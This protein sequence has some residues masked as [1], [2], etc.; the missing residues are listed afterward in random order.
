MYVWNAREEKIVDHS[1]QAARRTEYDDLFVLISHISSIL[2]EDPAVEAAQ[3][4]WIRAGQFL[5]EHGPVLLEL[6]ERSLIR[7]EIWKNQFDNGHC[8][9]KDE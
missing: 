8:E 9:S 1:K 5:H 7:L 4:S 3:H 6:V 2:S